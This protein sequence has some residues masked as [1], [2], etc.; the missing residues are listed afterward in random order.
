MEIQKEVI[1][2]FVNEAKIIAEAW[3]RDICSG[4]NPVHKHVDQ[5]FHIHQIIR[6]I[7][8]R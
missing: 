5:I 2:E 4:N 3:T 7:L 6:N 8:K 1:E